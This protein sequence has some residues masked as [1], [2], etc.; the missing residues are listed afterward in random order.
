MSSG[1]SDGAL[2]GAETSVVG[3]QH[4]IFG[5]GQPERPTTATL[6]SVIRSALTHHD[7][8]LRTAMPAKVLTVHDDF[9]VDLEP[10]F[11]LR[12]RN[13]TAGKT[14]PTLPVV[15][16]LMPVGASYGLRLPVAPG[17]TGLLLVLDR[18]ADTWLA[19][20]GGAVDPK[21]P[22]LH[23]LM[24][25]VFLPGLLP[26]QASK[27]AGGRGGSLSLEN[28]SGYVRIQKTG[29]IAIGTASQELLTALQAFAT[30]AGSVPGM[31]AAC[32]N[33]AEALTQLQ[34]GGVG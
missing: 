27:A 28:G 20:D 21:S 17:D 12:Y 4:P 7:K 33:L 9:T 3:E 2:L 32:A 23:A 1:A 13:E 10:G 14:M 6:S 19:G 25:A 29:G 18:S 26:K 30:T 15:P 34:T 16:V 8:A 11:K 22:N 24:D 5:T 31:Q